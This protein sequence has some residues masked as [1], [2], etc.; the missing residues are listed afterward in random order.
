M[1]DS[2]P[3]GEEA[4]VEINAAEEECEMDVAFGTG[5]VARCAGPKDPRQRRRL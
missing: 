4:D 2:E 5:C 3:E 1:S